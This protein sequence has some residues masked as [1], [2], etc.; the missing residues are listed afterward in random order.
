M[1][2]SLFS[3]YWYRVAKLKPLLRDAVQISRHVYRGQPW[4]VLRNTLS[5]SNHRFNAMAYALITQMDGRRTVNEIWEN[6]G[7]LAEEA[8]P[9]QD[10]I[11]QLLG[12][13]HEAN[14]IQSDILPSTV[15][16]VRQF[17]G[18]QSSG[19]KQRMMNPFSIRIPICNPDRFLSQWNHL[20]A[21]LFTR[22]A[23]FIWLIIVLWA[24][25]AAI[26]HWPELS[27]SLSDKLLSPGNLF[28]L[29]IVYPIVK[30]CHELGHAFA[31]KRWGG[32][33]HNMGIVLLALTPIPYV[34]ATASASFPDKSHRMAV[35]AM[36]MAVE[37]MLASIAM[38][39]WLN[40]ESGLTS[41]L[42][43]NVML[44]GGVSTLLFNGNPL[45]RYDGYYILADLIEIPN[46]GQRSTRYLGYLA[47]RYL[48]A[49]QDI[50]S[51]ITAKGE[52]SWFIVYGPISFCYRIAVLVGMVWLISSRFLG[53]GILIALWGAVS[54]LIL[55]A[56]RSLKQFMSSTAAS[57][58]HSRIFAGAAG[59]MGSVV[60]LLFFLPVPVRTTTQG[61][62]WLPEQATVRAGTDCEVTE[63]LVPVS[64]WVDQGT[65]IIRGD[66]PLLTT[67]IDV[68]KA[69]L[70]ELYATYNALP[71]HQRV[72]RKILMEEIK[73]A[74]ADL[75]EAQEKIDRLEIS[76][77]ASGKFILVDGSNLTGRYVKQGEILGYILSDHKPTVRAVVSQSDI[78]LVRDQVTGVELRLAEDA[79]R[80]LKADIK[81][82]VPAA[83]L[84][85]PS[86]ALGTN[87][88]GDIQIDPTDPQ[89]LRALE[90]VFQL[91][92]VL[93]EQV[94][95][96]HIGG[97]AH[98][99][100]EH[101]T[102]PL[103]LQWYRALRQLFL[104]K[105]YV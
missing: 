45:L 20:V 38:L 67:R 88:G 97:R 61:V 36:G 104:R 77:P 52:R 69:R 44:I 80:R 2:D 87:G 22:A 100:L 30:I 75:R 99:R 12:R 84:N 94:K 10:D 18:I 9:T 103:A 13:L 58:R 63:L 41:A 86:A 90:T 33:V 78:G 8:A 57:N 60:L 11:I 101:G 93:P 47:H 6:A 64:K 89:G 31:V 85:L 48:L 55:P 50:Q 46:L 26:M 17:R 70:K 5:G 105:F 4:Y 21:P 24:A 74:K 35:S 79:S 91:D 51:P 92:I 53:I 81:R 15:E 83:D 102:R 19:W 71:H 32:E 65:P 43:Y 27:S 39:V 49:S 54:L 40:V 66:D 16:L 76:S 28:L 98:V 95:D 25:G 59:L 1:S 68:Y 29:W 96:P 14:L 37:L 73:L 42:A 56:W 72:K 23:F 3:T 62:V 82:I 7:Q 34:D